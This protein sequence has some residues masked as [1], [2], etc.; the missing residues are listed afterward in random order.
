MKEEKEFDTNIFD[1]VTC[2]NEALTGRQSNSTTD[3]VL[4][5]VGQKQVLVFYWVINIFSWVLLCV[6]V[7]KS[8]RG[9]QALS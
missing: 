2:D 5:S 3:L 4:L 6:V 8:R 7:T 1:A 9:R